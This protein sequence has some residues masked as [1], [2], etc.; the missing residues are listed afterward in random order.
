MEYEK[1][2]QARIKGIQKILSRLPIKLKIVP[3]SKDYIIRLTYEIT[4]ESLIIDMKNK[5]YLSQ[6]KLFSS[7]FL[8]TFEER[9]FNSI[10]IWRILSLSRKSIV[11]Q[12]IETNKK[13]SIKYTCSNIRNMLMNKDKIVYADVFD[14]SII[15]TKKFL[16]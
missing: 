13:L 7:R 6:V 9:T 15:E 12:N 11:L 5:N 2:L 8:P 1:A 16:K 14:Y 4:D 10:I 3:I